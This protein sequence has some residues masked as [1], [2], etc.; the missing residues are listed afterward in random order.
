MYTLRVV[1]AL[2]KMVNIIIS[3]DNEMKESLAMIGIMPLVVSFAAPECGTSARYQ[4]HILASVILFVSVH[5][6]CRNVFNRFDEQFA[7]FTCMVVD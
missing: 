1:E 5:L 2:L 6:V 4:V 3:G 7:F